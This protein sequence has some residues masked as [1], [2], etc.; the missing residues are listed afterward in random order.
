MTNSRALQKG[1]RKTTERTTRKKEKEHQAEIEARK[2][3][4]LNEK[5]MVVH[6]QMTDQNRIEILHYEMDEYF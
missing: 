6:S 1:R 2:A 3:R 5:Y 4:K